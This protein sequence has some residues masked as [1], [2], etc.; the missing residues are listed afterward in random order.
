MLESYLTERLFQVKFADEITTLRVI[1]V[2]VPQGSLYGLSY[3]SSTPANSQHQ[4]TQ[5]LP[6][7]MIAS[8]KF[9]A[10]ISKIDDCAKG[11]E[12]GN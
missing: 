8:V 10:T 7:P 5:L 4:A 1:E 6:S 3:I 12:I 11:K 2:S 9:Q